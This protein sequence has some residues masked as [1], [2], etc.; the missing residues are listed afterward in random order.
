VLIDAGDVADVDEAAG[1]SGGPPFIG[2]TPPKILIPI[3][4]YTIT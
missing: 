2:P 1:R 3:S 4:I